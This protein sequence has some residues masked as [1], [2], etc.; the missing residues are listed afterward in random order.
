MNKKKTFI[1]ILLLLVAVF[2]FST[3]YAA[4]VKW[5]VGDHI[6]FEEETVKVML[7]ANTFITIF[8]IAV[9][10]IIIV[11]GTIKFVNAIMASDD[12]SLMKNIKNLGI[13]IFVGLLVF[14][15][16]TILD[17]ILSMT[18][19][20]SETTACTKCLFDRDACVAAFHTSKPQPEYEQPKN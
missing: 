6:C 5:N 12:K 20:Y 11:V 7:I 4:G 10:L 13:R 16:P 3:V 8:K 15:I 19:Y 1:F 9:P 14:F 18:N 2:A 17:A